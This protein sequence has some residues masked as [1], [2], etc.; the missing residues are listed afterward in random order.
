VSYA[1]A[2]ESL[3][4]LLVA[5]SS[6]TTTE[7]PT[8]PAQLRSQQRH[9]VAALLRMRLLVAGRLDAKPVPLCA[10]GVAL[11]A[12]D[13]PPDGVQIAVD[14]Y[15]AHALVTGCLTSGAGTAQRV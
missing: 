3:T 12:H 14:K 11:Q 13:R 2:Y 6:T 15:G 10:L 1:G 7:P 5:R 8:R 9:G 4:A